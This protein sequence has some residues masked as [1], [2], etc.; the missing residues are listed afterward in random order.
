[1]EQI[2]QDPSKRQEEAVPVGQVDPQ[3]RMRQRPP[4]R[5]EIL[6]HRP[7][8]DVNHVPEIYQGWSE[9]F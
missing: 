6:D 2:K 5:D 9:P 7:K 3:Q 8:R 1:M 4:T